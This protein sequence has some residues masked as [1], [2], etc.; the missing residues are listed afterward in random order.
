MR[1]IARRSN[2]LV[3]ELLR[4]IQERAGIWFKRFGSLSLSARS[5]KALWDLI[6]PLAL[7][8]GLEIFDI[9][10]PAKQRGV[11]RVSI[12]KQGDLSSGVGIDDCARVSRKI[13]ALDRIKAVLPEDVSLEV[14]SPGINRRLR[15]PEHFS[16]AVGEHVK[17]K[18]L[19]SEN[20]KTTLVGTLTEFDGN[21]IELKLDDSEENQLIPFRDVIEARIDFIFD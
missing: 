2:G 17:V 6:A 14:S 13:T 7:E 4:G 16:G 9:D 19:S 1:R 10:L 8:E 5:K 12:C 3:G 18:I 20:K 21:N 11:L 15:R